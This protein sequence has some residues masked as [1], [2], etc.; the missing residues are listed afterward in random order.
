MAAD[1]RQDFRRA[2]T[3]GDLQVIRFSAVLVVVA[4]GVLIGGI[5]TS[6][7]LLV[8]VAIGLSAAALVALAIGVVLKREELFSEQG[9]ALAPAAVGAGADEPLLAGK[10]STLPNGLVDPPDTSP[11]AG[12]MAAF[13]QAA[14]G[15]ERSGQDRSGNQAFGEPGYG[16]AAPPATQAPPSG[17]RSGRMARPAPSWRERPSPAYG[18]V[19]GSRTP[20][21][22][23]GSP[24]V[25]SP[26]AAPGWPSSPSWFDRPQPPAGP[27]RPKPPAGPDRPKAPA[28]P[29]RP[30]APA[31]PGPS[32]ADE[33]V[34]AEG[35]PPGDV[36]PEDVLPAASAPKAAVPK[37]PVPTATAPTATVQEA[38]PAPGAG[39]AQAGPP[40]TAAPGPG[41]DAATD[42]ADAEKAAATDAGSSE[43]SPK[44]VTVVQGVPR[45]HKEDCI[46]IRFMADDDVQKMTIRQATE[47]GCTPCR[48][49]HPDTEAT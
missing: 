46:L 29:D 21:P 25:G 40:E 2:R 3:R 26:S 1:H 42:G 41:A 7:L 16:Q 47:A 31:G 23:A 32:D 39:A 38:G 14:R 22:P 36:L 12:A 18:D 49:C 9:Q 20:A 34:T 44:Q 11:P 8:Y 17:D 5:A 24:P 28:G 43:G 13:G 4:I 48:A 35:A 45:Y 30:K 37:A 33:D 19:T 27:D 10:P 15:A 6:K